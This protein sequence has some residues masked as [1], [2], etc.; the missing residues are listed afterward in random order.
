MQSVTDLME[1]QKRKAEAQTKVQ[2]RS[3]IRSAKQKRKTEA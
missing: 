2:N 1:T 3:I